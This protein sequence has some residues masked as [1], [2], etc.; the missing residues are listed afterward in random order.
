MRYQYLPAV[1]VLV[2][3]A[4]GVIG[5][6]DLPACARAV[7]PPLLVI[8]SAMVTTACA[9]RLGAMD[10]LASA[11]FHR[12]GD[13]PVRL[14]YLTF[15]LSALTAALLNNDSTVLLVV[16]IVVSLVRRAYPD[17][18]ELVVALA[19][20]VFMAAG[21][22]P[23]VV[24]N[25]MNLIVAQYAGLD[26]NTYA[27]HMVPVAVTGW[28]AAL[29][30]LRWLL[31]R[32]LTRTPPSIGPHETPP[33][34][35]TPARQGVV[36]VLVVLAGYPVM[37]AVGGPLWAVSVPGAFGLSLLCRR[38]GRGTVV[39]VVRA[40]IAWDILVFLAGVST[41]A[42]GL[43][44]LG[45]VDGLASI[46]RHTGTAGI[47]TI[48]AVGSA[49]LNNHPMSLL[50]VVALKPRGATDAV[51]ILAALTGGD[52]GPRLLPWG[53][54][55][56]LLWFGVLGQLD[57]RVPAPRFI[58]IG[59]GVTLVCLPVCLLTLALSA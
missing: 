46:Y 35:D 2:F 56:G 1:V 49:V 39:E 15:V 16:P 54:L 29:A 25:P 13:S 44:H 14:F 28:L 17:S 11:L 45:V 37:A 58:A 19:L 57:V 12:G 21:V 40:A 34:W 51:P 55:A 52:L 22:A 50:N 59:L 38:H 10:R 27:R 30:T 23:L 33:S 43:D 47:G 32:E 9:R 7:W 41:V 31:R 18:P 26:F 8:T 36:L 5:S 6:R 4:T 24:S 48:S 3:L 53:S 20:V 42:V